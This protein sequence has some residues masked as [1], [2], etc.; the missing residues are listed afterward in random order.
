M[1]KMH[2]LLPGLAITLLIPVACDGPATTPLQDLIGI[3]FSHIAVPPGPDGVVSIPQVD[4]QREPDPTLVLALS[5]PKVIARRA[6]RTQR[7]V[8]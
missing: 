2:L 3:N 6:D 7:L 5:H 4:E 8:L 1:K